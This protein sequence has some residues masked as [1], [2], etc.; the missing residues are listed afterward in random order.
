MRERCRAT[1]PP[2]VPHGEGREGGSYWEEDVTQ[3]VGKENGYGVAGR[4]EE[5]HRTERKEGWKEGRKKGRKEGRG[6]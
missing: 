5:A 1:L 3:D 6:R 2:L 4:G